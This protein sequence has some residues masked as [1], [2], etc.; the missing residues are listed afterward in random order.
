M[1]ECD[2][3]PSPILK[4]KHQETQMGI[5]MLNYLCSPTLPQCCTKTLIKRSLCCLEG[6]WS[7]TLPRWGDSWGTTNSLQQDNFQIRWEKKRQL[8]SYC[9]NKDLQYFQCSR[10]TTTF[11][12][13]DD[14]PKHSCNCFADSQRAGRV[15]QAPPPFPDKIQITQHCLTGLI[16][17]TTIL[18][19]HSEILF[20]EQKDLWFLHINTT[21]TEGSCKTAS[22][23]ALETWICCKGSPDTALTYHQAWHWKRHNTHGR[24]CF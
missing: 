21:K 3:H 12:K 5:T 23:A 16:Q 2:Q 19:F 9:W 13:P 17:L 11:L 6:W 24:T 4:L 18:S 14:Q 8:S 1:L 20:W 22:V 7:M 10:S 15:S